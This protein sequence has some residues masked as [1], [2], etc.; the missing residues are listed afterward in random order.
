MEEP[1]EVIKKMAEVNFLVAT[2][3]AGVTFSALIQV[4]GGYNE[5]GKAILSK[6]KDFKNFF[7]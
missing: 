4:P 6:N 7:R 2:I 1:E 5:N 3:I